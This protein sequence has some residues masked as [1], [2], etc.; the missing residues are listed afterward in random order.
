MGKEAL[1][2]IYVNELHFRWFLL[3]SSGKTCNL[4]IYFCGETAETN[5]YLKTV[6]S[7]PSGLGSQLP[8]HLEQLA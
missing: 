3:L 4:F 1:K 6:P 8:V 2:P 7:L 5:M